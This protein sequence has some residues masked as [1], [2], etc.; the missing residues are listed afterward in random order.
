MR[1]L[2]LLALAASALGVLYIPDQI[3][4]TSTSLLAVHGHLYQT[5]TAGSMRCSLVCYTSLS[6]QA[7]PAT[8]TAYTCL[9]AS[10]TTPTLYRWSCGRGRAAAARSYTPA[11]PRSPTAT[12]GSSSSSRPPSLLSAATRTRSRSTAR[13]SA[14][15]APVHQTHILAGTRGA[16]TTDRST[17]P[18]TSPSLP[19]WTVSRIEMTFTPRTSSALT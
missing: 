9:S 8:L 10:S 3:V 7:I 19:S 12:T 6:Y 11:P 14:G 15:L 4:T 1:M 17:L 13:I 2:V 16:G 18:T 5:F